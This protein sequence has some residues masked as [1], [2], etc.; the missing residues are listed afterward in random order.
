MS[1]PCNEIVAIK[2]QSTDTCHDTD[3]PW[4][5]HGKK[6][7]QTQKATYFMIQ[8]IWNVNGLCSRVTD[9]CVFTGIE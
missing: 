7:S 4:K 1:Y 5:Q 3:K 8:F 6:K 2:E 9:S